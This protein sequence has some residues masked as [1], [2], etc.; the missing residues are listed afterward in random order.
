MTYGLVRQR[1]DREENQ[2]TKKKACSGPQ[3]WTGW[4]AVRWPTALA[5]V[6]VVHDRGNFVR[7]PK[8]PQTSQPDHQTVTQGFGEQ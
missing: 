7:L 8:G 2:L 3:E 5:C 6:E 4:S 1:Q